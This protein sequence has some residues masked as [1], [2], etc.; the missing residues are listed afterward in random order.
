MFSQLLL[1]LK[2]R[3][4]FDLSHSVRDILWRFGIINQFWHLNCGRRALVELTLLQLMPLLK[5]KLR[6]LNE[7][8]VS[9]YAYSSHSTQNSA[10]PREY[11]ISA[12][13]N[14]RTNFWFVSV[15]YFRGEFRTSTAKFGSWSDSVPKFEL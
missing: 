14:S 13:L 1:R 10:S 8:E 7:F 2:V 5:D 6:E 3:S 15:G 9:I 4:V 12:V 11:E